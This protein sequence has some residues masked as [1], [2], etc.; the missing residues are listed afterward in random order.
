MAARSSNLRPVPKSRST[1]K[2]QNSNRKYVRRVLS[3]ERDYFDYNLLAIV[4]LLTCFGLVMLYSTSAYEAMLE[5]AGDDMAY[6]RKQAVISVGAL[7]LALV[8]S[9]IDYH[10]SRRS[11]QSLQ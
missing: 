9:Q 3:T 4:I 6:F 10:F 7:V 5:S 8:G 2:T 11:L 1:G